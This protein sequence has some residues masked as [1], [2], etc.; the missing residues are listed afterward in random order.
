MKLS[1][2]SPT[3]GIAAIFIRSCRIMPFAALLPLARRRGGTSASPRSCRSSRNLPAV[4][5]DGQGPIGTCA[6]PCRRRAPTNGVYAAPIWKIMFH[7]RRHLVG[8]RRL[9]LPSTFGKQLT[10]AFMEHISSG[11]KPASRSGAAS[12]FPEG[13]T[14]GFPALSSSGPGASPIT[15]MRGFFGPQDGTG[16]VRDLRA[17]SWRSPSPRW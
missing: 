5:G 13:P 3:S 2:S 17:R 14:N 11:S 10:T 6:A 16:A 9:D 8:A 12:S 4:I 15:M 7:R 1:G